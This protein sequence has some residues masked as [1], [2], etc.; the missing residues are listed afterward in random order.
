MSDFDPQEEI[1]N[2]NIYR[3]LGFP[4]E[5]INDF[6][7][8]CRMA[9]DEIDDIVREIARENALKIRREWSER[10]C[11]FFLALRPY[12]NRNLRSAVDHLIS[13]G[14]SRNE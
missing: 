12:N 4:E 13:A 9:T 14:G 5:E 11:D 1:S 7:F 8:Y 6:Q 10:V 2:I 3:D